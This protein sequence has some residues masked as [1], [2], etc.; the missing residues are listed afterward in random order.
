MLG[1]RSN[2]CGLFEADTMYLD[3]VGRD[4]FYGY[5]ASQRGRLFRDEDFVKLYCLSNGRNSVPPSLLATALVLQ[6]HDRVSDA[7]AKDRADYDMRW[8]VALG[9]ELKDRPFAKSTLQLF[10]AQLIIHDKARG[11]FRRSLQKAKESGFLRLLMA[12]TAPCAGRKLP[13]NRRRVQPG[14]GK[15]VDIQAQRVASCVLERAFLH[16]SLSAFP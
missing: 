3:F 1:K 10:R 11:V 6:T 12:P 13:A 14:F 15:G 4:S 2:E 8:K 5:L 7:E 16:T 9:I